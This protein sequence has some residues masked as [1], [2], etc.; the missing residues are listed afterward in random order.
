M[1]TAYLSIGSN[2]GNRVANIARAIQA[3]RERGVSVTKESALYDT[4][5]VDMRT[6][7]WFVNSVIE[8]ETDDAPRALMAKLLVIERSMGRERLVPKGPRVIDIDILLFGNQTIGEKGLEIPHPRMTER[9]FVLVPLAE[10]APNAEHPVLRKTARELL[11]T[12]HDRSEVHPAEDEG[13]QS[14]AVGHAK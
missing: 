2:I 1:E 7:D 13:D 4:E 9:R 8:I 14:H 5:P 11:A 3:L 12:T 6:Q 10:I